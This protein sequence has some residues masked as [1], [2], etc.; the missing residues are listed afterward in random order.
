MTMARGP[1]LAR[2]AV[3]KAALGAVAFVVAHP[4]LDDFLRRQVY[5]FPRLAGGIRAVVGQSRRADWQP[6]PVVL[7]DETQLTDSARQ[8]LRDLRRA[9]D[10]TRRP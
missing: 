9:I 2:Q 8:V 4:R 7:S 1:S 3:K 6:P 10:Q 5:R